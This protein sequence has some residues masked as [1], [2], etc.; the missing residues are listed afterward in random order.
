MGLNILIINFFT[1]ITNSKTSFLLSLMRTFVFVLIGIILL[2]K[3][4]NIDGIW[5]SVPL[6]EL[7]SII[8]SLFYYV[9]Y[10]ITQ[11]RKGDL[12]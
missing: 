8:L 4:F 10:W 9:K 7:L 2:P 5:L 12:L 11:K 6:A 3:I 1:A